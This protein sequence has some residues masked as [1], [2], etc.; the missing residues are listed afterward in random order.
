MAVEEELR[1]N[2]DYDE[3]EF[4]SCTWLICDVSTLRD[5]VK[6]NICEL[7]SVFLF[8]KDEVCFLGTS[9]EYEGKK[10]NI[11]LKKNNIK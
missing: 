10:I 1:F 8:L 11:I 9:I 4:M 6:K 5:I 3:E 7:Q 2:G